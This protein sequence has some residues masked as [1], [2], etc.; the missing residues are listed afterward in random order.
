MIAEIIA[1]GSEMLTP[2]RQDTNSLYLTAALNDLGVQ[3]AYK[4]IVGDSLAHLTSAAAIAISRADI[5]IFSGGLGPTEDDL[6]RE[7]AAAA[8]GVELHP[9]NGILAALYKRFAA[10]QMV[11]PPNNAKQADV[12]DGALALDNKNGSAPG[13]YLDTVVDGHRKIVILL[14]GPPNELKPLFD[15]QVRPRLAA[16]LPIRHLAKRMLRMAL[17][18]ESHVDARTA[19]IY[20]QYPDVETTI[21]AHSGEIQLHFL[22]AKP[23]LSEAQARVDELTGKIEAEMEDAIFSSHGESLEEVVLLHL[24]MRHLTL[25][26]AESCTG[27]LLAQRLTAIPGS[28]RYFL[29]G[30]VVYSDALKTAFADVPAELI[31]THGPVSPEVAHSLAEGIRARTGASLGVSITGIAGPT[32]GSPGP[33]ANK[34]IGLVYIGL[35]DGHETQ[36]K[37]FRLP[38]DRDRI[39][40]WASQQAL[41]LVRRHLL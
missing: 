39:R 22:C 34:P 21:L 28:S 10:R 24:G 40:L 26:T 27:G 41:E 9:D 4:T 30:A 19:P 2:F 1:V 16:S 15:E 31:S 35:A 6:T 17:I 32:P 33:D 3:V 5:V 7:A 29:G 25:A 8:I 36:V 11:M 20:K 14:P 18:P 13:Q 23:T 38:G 37:E 12:L